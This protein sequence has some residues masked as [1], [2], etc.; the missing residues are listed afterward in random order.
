MQDRSIAIS[1]GRIVKGPLPHIDLSGFLILPGIIDLM[2]LPMRAPIGPNQA[3]WLLEDTDRRAAAFG[4]TLQY[5]CQGWSWEGP[6]SSPIAAETLAQ[7]LMRRRANT[8]IELRLALQVEHGLSTNFGRLLS[9]V[10]HHHIGLVLFSNR[11][12]RARHL[13]ETDAAEF[14]KLA[15]SLQQ[16]AETLSRT[17]DVLEKEAAAIPRALC[18]LAEHFDT[19][20]VIYG[21]MDDETGEAREHHSMIGAGLCMTPQSPK[22]AAAARAVSDPVVASGAELVERIRTRTLSTRDLMSYDALA[23]AGAGMPLAELALQLEETGLLPLE[24]AWALISNQPA[25]LLRLTDRG[26]LN[27]GCRA[28]M[29]IINARTRRVEATICGGRLAYL[30]GEAGAR[31]MDRTPERAIA[32]E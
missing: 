4:V 21:S 6:R 23:S 5:L 17:L 15:Q 13:C 32:A 26:R 1:Q 25:Q 8:A 28:D 30:S 14:R 18:D 29:T 3:E 22:A 2:G 16:D 24:K 7:T 19:M 12:E 31:F 11:A 9:L 10:R 20:G 27:S